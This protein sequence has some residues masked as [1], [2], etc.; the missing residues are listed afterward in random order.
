MLPCTAVVGESRLE[1]RHL[2]SDGRLDRYFALVGPLGAHD[3]QIGV[4]VNDRSTACIRAL[5]AMVVPQNRCS[6]LG[7]NVALV[8]VLFEDSLR[9]LS[10]HLLVH[11]GFIGV[12][13]TQGVP[14]CGAKPRR[15]TFFR[16]VNALKLFWASRIALSGGI[17]R[18]HARRGLGDAAVDY[19]SID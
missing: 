5:K 10:H 4:L 16:V 18:R 13:P 9:L 15:F 17:L 7:P 8:H 1:R 3:N 6:I 14:A 12:K 11:H 19:L 2:V